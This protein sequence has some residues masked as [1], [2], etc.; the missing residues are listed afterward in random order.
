MSNKIT[1]NSIYEQLRQA[2]K[3][4]YQDGKKIT[5]QR[6]FNYWCKEHNN[7]CP[8]ICKLEKQIKEM[9]N[10]VNCMYCD[11]HINKCQDCNN[12]S[13]WRFMNELR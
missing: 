5:E 12:Y 9:R 1:L 4:G 7:P 2:Y 13:E 3:N 10:C 8:H 11:T 6:I